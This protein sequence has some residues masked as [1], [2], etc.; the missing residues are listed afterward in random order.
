MSKPSSDKPL[1]INKN[2]IMSDA[3]K[4]LTSTS[5]D[6]LMKFFCKRQMRK[7]KHKGRSNSWEIS[8]NGEIEYCYSEAEKDGI[9][10]P[11]FQRSIDQLIEH[12][13][14]EITHQGSGGRKGDKSLYALVDNWKKFGTDEFTCNPREINEKLGVG[15]TE[16]H[17][18]QREKQKN[19]GKVSVT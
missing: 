19:I 4:S 17:R 2:L 12:G 13:F 1:V 16:Y 8:N 5:K 10:R 11:T 7:V 6:V 15:F 14:I 3:F 18:Q 9:S